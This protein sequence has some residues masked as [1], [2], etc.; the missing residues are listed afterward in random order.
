M[1]LN[2]EFSE[3]TIREEE[4]KKLTSTTSKSGNEGTPFV[5]RGDIL[6]LRIK[7]I[8]SHQTNDNYPSAQFHRSTKQPMQSKLREIS[9]KAYKSESRYKEEGIL[10][11][12]NQSTNSD[13]NNEESKP[14]MMTMIMMMRRRKRGTGGDLVVVLGG[15]DEGI[16]RRGV[17]SH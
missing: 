16:E 10:T 9:H 12:K 4:R 13:L 2:F 14:Y 5:P 3:S 11:R 1:A 15:D 6:T 7:R 8:T 17:G